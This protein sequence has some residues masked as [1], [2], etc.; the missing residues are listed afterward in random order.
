MPCIV[1]GKR[2]WSHG[3]I[4]DENQVDNPPVLYRFKLQRQSGGAVSWVPKMIHNASGIGT[5]I[6]A[7]DINK[8]GKVEILTSARKGTFVFF[9]TGG[10]T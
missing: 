9:D 6:L 4:Y 8:D 10:K 3:Y 7:K 1:T 5:Q 2:W